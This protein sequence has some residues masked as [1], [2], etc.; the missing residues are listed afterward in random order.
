M[1]AFTV[2]NMV[3]LY[4]DAYA[5]G[6]GQAKVRGVQNALGMAS[7]NPTGAQNELMRFGAVEE[8]GS[9]DRQGAQR[10][11]LQRREQ[12]RLRRREIGAQAA[13][14]DL[15]GARTAALGEGMGDLATTIGQMDSQQR[16]TAEKS[17]KV[18]GG[19]A[20]QLLQVRDPAQ[21]TQL[22][23]AAIQ[24]LLQQ[25]IITPE[26]AAQADLSDGSLQTMVAQAVE[27][28]DLIEMYKQPNAPSGY[29]W[30]EDGGLAFIPGGPAD[31]AQ[32]GQ[33]SGSRRDAVVSR[34]MP[35]RARPAASGG[36]G[37]SGLP[38]GFTERVR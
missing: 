5:T 10:A 36:G 13:G 25:Q 17:S 29:Q 2:P 3:G 28:T 37:S 7:T 12:E 32:V 16:E 22:G 9:I 26:Q 30:G 20:Y 14:G 4:N 8:A 23:Q 15:A 31:P 6:R 24:Q 11:E 21:R 38:P 34:P 1:V 18:L 35:T 33:I 27:V 19:I